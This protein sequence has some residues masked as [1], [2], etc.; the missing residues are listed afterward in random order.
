MTP[1]FPFYTAIYAAVLG[2]LA[3]ILTVNVIVTWVR[4]KVDMA[5]GGVA[6]LAASDPR[7]RKFR[8]AYAARS[9][10]HWSRGSVRLS[11]A[12]GQWAG[13][14]SAGGAPS[15]RLGLEFIAQADSRAA[16]AKRFAVSNSFELP[17]GRGVHARVPD[18]IPPHIDQREI[19]R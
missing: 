1:V 9:F 3:A 19:A 14:R 4:T 12:R 6:P 16:S 7:A 13:R 17:Q 8:R 11:L 5:D 10:A 2:L 18:H 15:Q